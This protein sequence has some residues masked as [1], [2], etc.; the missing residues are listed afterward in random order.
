MIIV[1]GNSRKMSQHCFNKHTHT[2]LGS[3][4]GWVTIAGETQFRVQLIFWIDKFNKNTFALKYG[5]GLA[6][7]WKFSYT[8]EGDLNI[9][10]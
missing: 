6:E 5:K 8:V 1:A 10:I 7:E 3:H 9:Q 2:H 4:V